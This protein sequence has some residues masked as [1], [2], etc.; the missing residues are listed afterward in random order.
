M[1]QKVACIIPAAGFGSVCPDRSASKVVADTM[2]EPMICR[3]ARTVKEAGLSGSLVVVVGCSSKNAYANQIRDVLRLAGHTD[4]RFAVQPD[5]FGAADA[6]SRGITCL[7]GE[8]H[9]LVTFPD[10]PAWR[11]ETHRRLVE[12]H[13]ADRAVITMATIC[14]PEGDP[15][16]TYGRIA[17]D[18]DGQIIAVFEPSELN[19][20]KLTGVKTVNPSLYVFRRSW[21]EANFNLIPPVSKGDGYPAERHLPKFLPIAHRQGAKILEVPVEDYRE[22]LGVNNY[23]ELKRVREVLSRRNG[24][25]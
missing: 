3:V 14:P 6:V 15:V 8:G 21:Y 24:D 5:R 2:G 13:L 25:H 1:N 18:A 19:G 7:N 12:A 11:L 20:R 4:V 9:F 17:R 10:M 16:Q 23:E 22:A